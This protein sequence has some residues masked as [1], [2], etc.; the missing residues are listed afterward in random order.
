MSEYPEMLVGSFIEKESGNHVPLTLEAVEDETNRRKFSLFNRS[1][2]YLNKL[3]LF[4]S[5]SAN[6]FLESV[7]LYCE[8][9]PEVEKI[10]I[11]QAREL[12]ELRQ[13]QATRKRARTL[14]KNFLS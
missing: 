7:L 2:Y 14:S 1:T 12:Q 4:Y 10:L 8:A 3:K 13:Q 9:N 5:L 6:C 11:A